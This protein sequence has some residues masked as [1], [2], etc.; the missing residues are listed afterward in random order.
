L[1]VIRPYAATD[2]TD[3]LDIWY[4]ASLVAHPFLSEQFLDDES[5]QIA[6]QWLPAAETLVY[7][8][9]GRRLGSNRWSAL[10]PAAFLSLRS[11]MSGQRTCPYGLSPGLPLV[12][13]CSF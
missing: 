2:L 11:I 10:K 6:E 4:R 12:S 5:Q 13:G 8:I 3:V 9:G 1:P 7:E